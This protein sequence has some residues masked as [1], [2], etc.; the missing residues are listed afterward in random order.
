MYVC[1][2]IV[3]IQANFHW[4]TDNIY[5]FRFI[6][7]V[8][9][10]ITLFSMIYSNEFLHIHKSRRFNQFMQMN[11]KYFENPQFLSPWFLFYITYFLLS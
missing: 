7:E 5:L 1:K 8:H 9:Y 4:V 3:Y 11:I 10:P 6:I 2:Y